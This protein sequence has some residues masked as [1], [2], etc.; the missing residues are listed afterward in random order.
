M[1]RCRVRAS[2]DD[3][4]SFPESSASHLPRIRSPFWPL[5]PRRSA[6]GRSGSNP[7][8]VSRSRAP[9]RHGRCARQAPD[10]SA[11]SRRRCG[12]GIEPRSRRR[13]HL[14]HASAGS[15][16]ANAGDGSHIWSDF[17]D[18]RLVV[19]QVLIQNDGHDAL[20]RVTVQVDPRS[21]PAE[22]ERQ[23][24]DLLRHALAIGSIPRCLSHANPTVVRAESIPSR[25]NWESSVATAVAL[26]RQG[27][28]DK[29]VLAREERL[30]AE[31][32]FSPVSTLCAAAPVR[33]H[34][35]PLR[36]AIRRCLV[37]R[38]HARSAWS[39]CTTTEST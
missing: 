25:A 38:R 2:S 34:G 19:P 6:P 24:R 3:R 35:D 8:R 14:S 17:P 11:R 33:F 10:D 37:H 30:L 1:T 16:S 21:S 12:S 13:C 29:V 23:M 9:G 32:P 27:A 22:V 36:H 4:R 28:L 5:A 20:L 7:V 15:P 18:A 26:I 39:G 31:S